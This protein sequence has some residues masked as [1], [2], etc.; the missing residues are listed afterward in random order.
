MKLS[1]CILNKSYSLPTFPPGNVQTGHNLDLITFI[2]SKH[3]NDPKIH[4]LTK[5][6][7][8]FLYQIPFLKIH[9]IIT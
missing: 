9:I 6:P 5:N 7:F 4:L 8:P 1:H 2:K 3:G